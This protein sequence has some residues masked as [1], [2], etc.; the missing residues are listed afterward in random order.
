MENGCL[1]LFNLF[2]NKPTATIVL[3]YFSFEFDTNCF[4]HTFSLKSNQL[5]NT[6][7]N[8]LFR[9]ANYDNLMKWKLII[10]SQVPSIF[11]SDRYVKLEEPLGKGA[12]GVVEKVYD[13]FDDKYYAMK[14]LSNVCTNRTLLKNSVRELRLLAFFNHPNVIKFHDAFLSAN[15][16]HIITELGSIDL[17][18]LLH[19]NKN[20]LPGIDIFSISKQLMTAIDYIHS[21][22]IMHRDIKPSNVLL[23]KS[24]ILKLCDFGMSRSF[25][26]IPSVLS[27]LD[28]ILGIRFIVNIV[29]NYL[30]LMIFK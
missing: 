2:D 13:T 20:I 25:S 30:V 12:F 18:H 22:C 14:S 10:E 26:S 16:L 23:T 19:A 6:K 4:N 24:G 15:S 17:L 9:V 5:M 3:L 29:I 21:L 11:D 8:H 1:L 28:S 27:S 7:S